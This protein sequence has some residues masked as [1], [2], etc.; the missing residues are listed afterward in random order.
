VR[1][2][3]APPKAEFKLLLG[4][5]LTRR[6]HFGFNVVFE[7]EL[8]GTLE[9]EYALTSGISYTLTDETFALG[10]EVQFE[11][12]DTAGDRF[13]FANWELLAGPSLAWSPTRPMHILLV[14]LLGNETEGDS[15]TPLVEPTLILG[16]EI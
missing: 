11:T 7:H 8:G 10:A 3:D 14:A 9:N 1:Q 13:A 16:W 5:S 6:L 2:H 4:D 12:V 15:H